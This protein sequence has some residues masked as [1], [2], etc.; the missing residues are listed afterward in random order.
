MK[1]IKDPELRE[2]QERQGSEQ[3]RLEYAAL[4]LSARHTKNKRYSGKVYQNTPEKLQAIKE[5]YKNG[6]TEEMLKSWLE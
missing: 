5:K 6:V 2:Y 4:Y 1:V 3:Y